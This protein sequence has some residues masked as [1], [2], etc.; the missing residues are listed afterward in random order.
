MGRPQPILRAAPAAPHISPGPPTPPASY[1]LESPV[2]NKHDARWTDLRKDRPWRRSRC[3]HVPFRSRTHP[4]RLARHSVR[5][6]RSTRAGCFA[7]LPP[8]PGCCCG[9]SATSL[10]PVVRCLR[11]SRSDKIAAMDRSTKM[12]LW[13]AAIVL[14]SYFVWFYLDCAMD[15]ACR[16]VCV[17]GG[18]GGCHTQWTADP[19]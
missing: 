10:P 7:A 4:L 11:L 2:E 17:N 6:S 13:V 18:R 3:C 5:A 8:A 1:R 19:K 16:I 14:G 9:G 12:T 15:D